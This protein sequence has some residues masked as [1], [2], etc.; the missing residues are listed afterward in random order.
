MLITKALFVVVGPKSVLSGT[1]F[2]YT[3]II[4]VSLLFIAILAIVVIVVIVC[5]Q[6]NK[7]GAAY[8]HS[9]STQFLMMFSI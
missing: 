3:T 4:L 9:T 5:R 6:K 2:M 8:I 7:A 1:A